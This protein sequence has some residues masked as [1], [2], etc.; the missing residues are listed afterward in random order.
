MS[1]NFELLQ[2]LERE[3]YNPADQVFS[4]EESFGIVTANRWAQEEALRLVQQVFLPQAQEP[5]RLTVFAGVD[6]GNG[7]SYICA[8]V[9]EVL[10]RSAKKPVCLVDANFRS[11]PL[12]NMFRTS[13]QTGLIDSL[14]DT[15][16]ILRFANPIAQTNLWLLS[17]G[18]PAFES[19]KLLNS[20]RLKDRLSELRGEFEYVIVDAPPLTLYSDALAL[21][22]LSDG[23]VMVL[24]AESTR[25]DAASVVAANLRLLNIPILA[26]VLNKRTYPIPASI[27]SRI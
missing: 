13:N 2:H 7:C 6:H 21:G 5:P 9:A 4:M 23:L 19:P 20:A 16:P 17:S 14:I 26:A 3:R 25:R 8:S 18:I 11:P 27:Y 15:D 22:Q 1:K 10:A 12:S 24:E